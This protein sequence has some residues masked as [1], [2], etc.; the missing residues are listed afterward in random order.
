LVYVCFFVFF[1]SDSLSF[2]RPI[3]H[4]L[5]QNVMLSVRCNV[6]VVDDLI[7]EIQAQY[8]A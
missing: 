2:F 4:L 1:L 3:S 6:N 5:D 8:R 7:H